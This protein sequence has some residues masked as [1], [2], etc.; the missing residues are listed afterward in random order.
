MAIDPSSYRSTLLDQ[1][2]AKIVQSGEQLRVRRS[3]R[4]ALFLAQPAFR[5]TRRAG[6]WCA[7]SR[8][9]GHGQRRFSAPQLLWLLHLR[10]QVHVQMVREPCRGPEVC[11][12]GLLA[13]GSHR[14]LVLVAWI[15]SAPMERAKQARP[16]DGPQFSARPVVVGTEENVPA[17]RQG[18]TRE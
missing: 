7:Q 12:T 10:R 3:W 5:V 13:R 4:A 18:H 15:G 2:V 6:H 14:L 17:D 8:R 16:G 11:A 1:P 9:E